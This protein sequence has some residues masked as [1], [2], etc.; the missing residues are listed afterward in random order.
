MFFSHLIEW[1]NKAGTTD[2]KCKCGSWKEHWVNISQ[3]TWPEK[4]GVLGCDNKADVGAHVLINGGSKE[5]IMPMCKACN[6]STDNF[7]KKR[8]VE[9][10]SANKNETCEK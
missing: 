4:C 8:T 3:N 6:A 10:V 2:R 5:Y 9:V 1:K 7:R